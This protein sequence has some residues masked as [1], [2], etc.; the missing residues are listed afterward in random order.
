M[1]RSYG[2]SGFP[3]KWNFRETEII[4]GKKECGLTPSK[5]QT[6]APSNPMNPEELT[7]EEAL[8]AAML[9]GFEWEPCG[10][11]AEFGYYNS[12]WGHLLMISR[13]VAAR[14]YL[15]LHLPKK[16]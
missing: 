5:H 9:L 1:K 14:H 11:Y 8:A 3:H 7:D 2:V 10:N 15:K 16:P 12:P 13:I 4:F 6:T